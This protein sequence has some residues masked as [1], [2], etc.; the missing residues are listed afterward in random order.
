M[1]EQPVLITEEEGVIGWKPLFDGKTFKGI[2][3]WKTR[4]QLEAGGWS[5][6]DGV[7][8]LAARS[9]GGDIYFPASE[10]ENYI[11]E[12]EWKSEGNSGIFL[13]VDPKAEGAIWANALEMQIMDDTDEKLSKHSAGALFDIIGLRKGTKKLAEDGW[14]KVR[15]ECK[16]GEF[17]HYLNDTPLYRYTVGDETW[18]D[19][20]LPKSKF[21]D[22]KNFGMFKKGV[23]G[24]QDH[25]DKVSF[26]NIKFRELTG[27]DAQNETQKLNKE[28][29]GT[30]GP[31]IS[32]VLSGNDDAYDVNR[33]YYVNLLDDTTLVGAV[34][35]ADTFQ[36][37]GAWTNGGGAGFH[38]L[39][40]QNGRCD[41]IMG[42]EEGAFR[43]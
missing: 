5:I 8:T 24:L 10:A 29:F 23:I 32:N 2:N 13:R 31:V 37:S 19:R 36:L 1:A 3:S 7:L 20:R 4:K 41:S 42:R 34:F 17:T 12:L 43:F 18:F 16:N 25:G 21:K 15:I 6:E 40:Y 38:G 27:A 30:R 11:L 35:N 39:P 26:R 33:A 9:G 22:N 14:N 28:I